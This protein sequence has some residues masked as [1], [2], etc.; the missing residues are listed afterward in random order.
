MTA[1]LACAISGTGLSE[2][3]EAVK[4]MVPQQM[5]GE[6][7]PKLEQTFTIPPSSLR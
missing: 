4:S 7:I 6:I 3:V 5:W 1:D 2:N